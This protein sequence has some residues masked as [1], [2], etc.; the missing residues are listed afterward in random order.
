MITV[1]SNS[2]STYEGIA[3]Q[4]VFTFSS[5]VKGEDSAFQKVRYSWGDNSK[6]QTTTAKVT[7][8]KFTSAGTYNVTASVDY[9]NKGKL[10]TNT[11]SFRFFIKPVP[12]NK[13]DII[14]TVRNDKDPLYARSTN[15]SFVPNKDLFGTNNERIKYI[16]WD[17]GNG[18]I[19]NKP[20]LTGVTFDSPGMFEIKLAVT[21]TDNFVHE[22]YQ[23]I[24]I[25]EYINDSIKFTKVPPPTYAGHINRFPFEI[26]VTSP[27]TNGQGN[28]VDLY[29]QFSRSYDM[30][31]TPNK[32]SFLRP[33]WK[34]L[35]TSPSLRPIRQ[36][37]TTNVENIRINEYGERVSTGGYF[38][39]VKERASFYFIDD[40]YNQ[41]QV[42]K[43]EQYTTIWAT[44]RSNLIRNNKST[45]NIDGLHP[46]HANNTAQTWCPYVTLWR[47]PEIIKYT[48]NGVNPINQNP[49]QGSEVPFVMSLGYN[50]PIFPNNHNAENSIRLYDRDG[51]FA[52]YVPALN[53]PSIQLEI[54]EN[55]TKLPLSSSFTKIEVPYIKYKDDD[56]LLTGGYYRN[57]Y[58]Y[59]SNYNIFFS[60][61]VQFSSKAEFNE[62]NLEANNYNPNLW[63]LNPITSKIN[64]SQYIFTTNNII[65]SPQYFYTNSITNYNKLFIKQNKPVPSVK[66][67][68]NMDTCISYE[69][70]M[71]TK[72][73]PHLSSIF[74]NSRYLSGLHSVAALNFPTYHAW[75]SDVEL[76]KIYRVTCDGKIYR[77]I[78]L[79]TLRINFNSSNLI[80]NNLVLDKNL[81]L[82]ASLIGSRHILKFNDNGSL[83]TS[84]NLNNIIPVSIDVDKDDNL[85]ISGIYRDQ[86]QKSVLLKYNSSLTSLLLSKEYN[87]CFLGN[88]LVSPNNKIYVVNNGHLNKDL[89]PNYSNNSFIEVLNTSTFSTIKNLTTFPFIKH[90]SIDK[91]E[92]IIFNYGLNSVGRITETG[93]VNK[94]NIKNVKQQFDGVKNIIEGVSYNINNKIYIINSIDNLVHVINSNTF[95][96]EK[97][98]YINPSNISYKVNN[99]GQLIRPFVVEESK[100][101]L[102]IRSN[103]DFVGWRW[104][105]KYTYKKTPSKIII[106]TKSPLITFNS[107][108]DFKVFNI[109]ENFDMSRYMYDVSH[110][111]TLKESPFLYNNRIYDDEIKGI[112]LDEANRKISPLQRELDQLLSTDFGVTGGTQF[113][114]R[115]RELKEQINNE[116]DSIS[117]LLSAG[118]KQKGFFGSILGTFPFSP[119]DLGVSTYSKIANFVSNTADI[120][121]CNVKHLYDIMSKIDYNDE[122]YKIQFPN[123]ISRVV[124]FL[125]ISPKKLIGVQCRCGDTFKLNQYAYESCKFCGREKI[126]NRGK[127]II[128]VEYKVTAGNPVVLK[129]KDMKSKYRKINTGLLNNSN[130]YTITE[131]ATSIGLPL[132]WYESYEFFEYVPIS[133]SNMIENYI[134]W[135]NPQTSISKNQDI[136]SWY[137]SNRT[138]ERII[139]FELQKGLELI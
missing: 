92:S 1:T 117:S 9:L 116:Y 28:I 30:L 15:F 56:K 86:T 130:K 25:Q 19:S 65:N 135:S 34:F 93:L 17:L 128:D 80:P 98:F 68:K 95:L 124:D 123:G 22:D 63:I 24:T 136:K 27:I 103:G 58:K 79:K 84:L 2:N 48:R 75:V 21:T 50:N 57:T 5:S 6:I 43:N 91:N 127:K 122:T 118:N 4:T 110:M 44:L 73:S 134:D 10:Y 90:L 96:E 94:L 76:D 61:V 125:S 88:I 20:I 67:N 70:P 60:T 102:G 51:G 11:V 129:Y 29:A 41:D 42:I 52:H 105:Y 109:N 47:N 85:Y 40:W 39:G 119:D 59:Y 133:N 99:Q 82:Y 87:N 137:D 111:K 49:W 54:I 37:K 33:E 114:D 106:T 120:D 89:R 107:K 131:L 64:V 46:S 101:S 12:K 115:I 23:I 121:L 26:E 113:Q 139:D 38:V 74:D 104:N 66:S 71:E 53:E 97:S 8:K 32:N 14:K 45:D 72:K 81:N 132:R 35:D 62:P 55:T 77:N 3:N 108:N 138:V 18:I 78:N 126:S 69:I 7:T 13:F 16:Q 112:I 83:L 31:D 36:I 100:N